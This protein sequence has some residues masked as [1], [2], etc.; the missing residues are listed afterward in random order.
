VHATVR[1]AEGHSQAHSAHAKE[2]VCGMDKCTRSLHTAAGQRM[3]SH[4]HVVHG[5]LRG[6]MWCWR[7]G[8]LECWK[9]A[10]AVADV[11]VAAFHQVGKVCCV[12]CSGKGTAGVSSGCCLGL[13]IF[14]T[15]MS[16]VVVRRQMQAAGCITR[17]KTHPQ[18][19][20]MPLQDMQ[21]PFATDPCLCCQLPPFCVQAP[22]GLRPPGGSNDSS[23]TTM[24]AATQLQLQRSVVAE[25][26]RGSGWRSIAAR[27][28]CSL[29]LCVRLC[30]PASSVCVC[31]PFSQRTRTLLRTHHMWFSRV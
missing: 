5:K 27:S 30:L 26:S 31:A 1:P 7:L 24:H 18:A 8:A 15:L 20:V 6:C 21:M 3:A 29:C 23:I 17:R 13:A 12:E 19:S 11:C 14:N 16:L 4:L 10:A 25:A 22:T 2:L 28:G 9:A